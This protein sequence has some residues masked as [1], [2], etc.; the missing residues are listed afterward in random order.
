M[1]ATQWTP[2]ACGFTP[3]ISSSLKD[4]HMQ[5]PTPFPTVALSEDENASEKCNSIVACHKRIKRLLERKAVWEKK[6]RLEHLRGE[7]LAI[8]NVTLSTALMRSK[9]LWADVAT[10]K[11]RVRPDDFENLV[12]REHPPARIGHVI[13]SSASTH[14]AMRIAALRK[15][16]LQAA[17]AADVHIVKASATLHR[18][19]AKSLAGHY[20]ATLF[21]DALREAYAVL[22]PRGVQWYLLGDDDT[23][24]DPQVVAD[25]AGSAN[26]SRVFGNIYAH[27]EPSQPLSDWRPHTPRYTCGAS[28]GREPFRLT[29]YM[30]WFTG[31]SGVLLPAS[32]VRRIA[33][34]PRADIEAWGSVGSHCKCGDVPLACALIDLGVGREHRP[35]LF[36]D[37]CITCED[38]SATVPRRI[39]S[40]H[41]AEAFSS[42]NVHATHKESYDAKLLAA[43]GI[44][45]RRHGF[46]WPATL[47][48][49]EPVDR[50]LAVQKLLC[51][52]RDRTELGLPEY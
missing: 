37:S 41:A 24:V 29:T 27:R 2:L 39:L 47:Q 34:A 10:G 43:H 45:L 23:H 1:Q 38:F 48:H 32:V 44:S 21:L 51:G 6:A 14:G 22:D 30:S 7:R 26:V 19:S 13:L 31:G 20:N 52:A 28:R 42:T 33:T 50:M 11:H 25:F 12:V 15:G 17:D 36:L 4:T 49:F 5:D 3:V 46:K 18:S 35:E 9:L 16:W 40:C 8:L